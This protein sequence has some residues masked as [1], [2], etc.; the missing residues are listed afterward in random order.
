MAIRINFKDYNI[1][2]KKI[3]N[4][5][6]IIYIAIVAATMVAEYFLDLATTSLIILT[7]YFISGLLLTGLSIKYPKSK[8]IGWILI[9]LLLSMLENHFIVNPKTFHIISF[10]LIFIPIITLLVLG[11]RQALIIL[12]L[13]FSIHATNFV[14]LSS[15][16]GEAY[17]LSIK[18]K[19]LFVS[20]SIFIIGN[21][22]FALLLYKLL[23]NAYV[24]MSEKKS[25]L[26]AKNEILLN[27]HKE[28]L[29]INKIPVESDINKQFE[30]I[31]KK[32]AQILNITRVSIWLYKDCNQTLVNTH[33]F[34]NQTDAFKTMPQ[35]LSVNEYPAYFNYLK[36]FNIILAPNVKEHAATKDLTDTYLNPL[37]ISSLLD[38]SIIVDGISIGIICCENQYE[39][40]EFNI[41]DALFI[42]SLSDY[43]AISYKNERIKILLNEIQEKNI[44]LV[45]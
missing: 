2:S 26:N 35:E 24:E 43:I 8:I 38:C 36:D 18:I 44:E 16:T 22:F 9:F 23:G 27:Y 33:Q 45:N 1:Y 21:V 14:Y 32:A 3:Y 11:I 6:L 25:A 13:V 42:Q 30:Y 12:L 19:P 20:S 4:T 5:T 29:S 17:D 10:W 31:C 40:K 7:P 41:E 34:F 15:I 39:T 37:H 28:I